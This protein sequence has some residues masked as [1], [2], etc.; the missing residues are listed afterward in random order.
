MTI[1]KFKQKFQTSIMGFIKYLEANYL[2]AI[3]QRMIGDTKCDVIL[4][5]GSC[6]NLRA[7]IEM[8][9]IFT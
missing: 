9:R 6:E 5:Q 8:F 4:T 1:D 3:A 7:C 2:K